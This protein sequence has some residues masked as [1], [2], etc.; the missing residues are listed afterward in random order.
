MYKEDPEQYV[1]ETLT[2][3]MIEK[4]KKSVGIHDN[5]HIVVEDTVNDDRMDEVA[6]NSERMDNDASNT[7][8][9][10]DDASGVD[11]DLSFN[12]DQ[13]FE[14]ND[15][16]ELPAQLQEGST[17][18][19]AVAKEITPTVNIDRVADE[20]MERND[21][22]SEAIFPE[23]MKAMVPKIEL[24]GRCRGGRSLIQCLALKYDLSYDTL[25]KFA[26]TV[27]I[28]KWW[29]H[30]IPSFKYPVKIF[31]EDQ[32]G[33]RTTKIINLNY[34]ICSKVKTTK[35]PAILGMLRLSCWQVSSINSFTYFQRARTS[36]RN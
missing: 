5:T 18:V 14:D 6:S 7:A 22:D 15:P 16:Y 34:S 36:R 9:V 33:V 25:H 10:K 30:F 19:A 8:G 21:D 20:L 32:S 12:G 1:N 26:T 29:I 13:S 23:I 11:S 3:E 27:L 4:Q 17:Q 28:G 35:M 2:Q 24:K 31:L